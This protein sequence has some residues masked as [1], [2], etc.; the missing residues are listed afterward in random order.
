M[1]ISLELTYYKITYTDI[2][3]SFDNSKNMFLFFYFFIFLFFFFIWQE[4]F[5]TGST[6]LA[7]PGLHFSFLFYTHFG[8]S[9]WTSDQPVVRHLPKHRQHRHRETHIHVHPCP[10]W[11]RTHEYSVRA[12]E[13]SSCLR[14]LGYR[15]RPGKLTGEIIYNQLLL[16]PVQNVWTY[17]I[18]RNFVP[19]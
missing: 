16:Y 19:A 9:P 3:C 13:D 14:P 6:A 10:K 8:K 4:N 17:M 1:P 15:D 2:V 5:F 18:S 7:G 11:D 12:S